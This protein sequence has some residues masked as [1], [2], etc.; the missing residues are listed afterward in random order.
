M[1]REEEEFKRECSDSERRN[2]GMREKNRRVHERAKR[3]R[4]EE[5]AN[6]GDAFR[7]RESTCSGVACRDGEAHWR[8][9][10]KMGRA[11]TRTTARRGSGMDR[12]DG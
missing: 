1:G 9:Q 5:R 10:D 7:T 8:G 4:K 12:M 3:D 6:R 2:R 11:G